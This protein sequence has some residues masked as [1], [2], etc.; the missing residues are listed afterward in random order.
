MWG[1]RS[2]L[3]DGC[4][5]QPLTSERKLPTNC[6]LCTRQLL[7]ERLSVVIVNPTTCTYSVS[8][9]YTLS[10]ALLAVLLSARYDRSWWPLIALAF[11]CVRVVLCLLFVCAACGERAP[12]VTRTLRLSRGPTK[13][14]VAAM[15]SRSDR[16]RD[17]RRMTVP[18]PL[19]PFDQ[20][21]CTHSLDRLGA[22]E[23]HLANVKAAYTIGE[24]GP[25]FAEL[26]EG[27]VPVDRSEMVDAAVRRDE[28]GAGDVR[29]KP[30]RRRE[31]AAEED[32]E[33]FG[34]V[35]HGHG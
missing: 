22:T 16:P 17:S 34:L 5:V 35:R 25:R 10:R 9:L 11:M 8:F 33:F 18:S 7:H 6:R 24:A 12:S 1:F 32:D 26:L 2:R 21:L 14:A 3:C 15:G 29:G 27:R 13:R 28:A 23:A 19:D 30:R 20:R 4:R 31:G